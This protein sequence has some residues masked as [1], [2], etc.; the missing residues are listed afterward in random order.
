M[1]AEFVF[2]AFFAGLTLSAI[3]SL[4]ASVFGHR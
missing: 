4:I 2:G 3:A 1:T